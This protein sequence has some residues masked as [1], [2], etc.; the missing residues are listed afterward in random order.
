MRMGC[1]GKAC[2]N[3]RLI[4]VFASTGNDD[5]WVQYDTVFQSMMEK[6]ITAPVMNMRL[7]MIDGR[8][9]SVSS[10]VSVMT[11]AVCARG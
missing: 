3:S 4:T 8:T 9:E 5:H 7:R 11:T 10:A 2:P 1:A 6:V